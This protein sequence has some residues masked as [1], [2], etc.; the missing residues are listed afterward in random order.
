MT[1]QDRGDGG[2]RSKLRSQGLP[3][4]I[5]LDGDGAE[6]RLEPGARTG[7]IRAVSSAISRRVE[8]GSVVGLM[9]P[10]SPELVINWLASVH[11]GMK[12]V[13]MQYPTKKQNRA[14]WADSVRN[15]VGLA[16]IAA[17]IC[18]DLSASLLRG[19]VTIIAQEELAAIPDGPPE[20]FELDDF[21]IV[22]LSSGTTGHRKAIEFSWRQLQR[23]V[24]D[25]NGVLRLTA[26]DRVVS[27]LPLYHD[28]GYIAC[29]VMPMILGVEVVMVDPMAW[30]RRPS[31]LFD[32]VETYSGTICYMPN[33]GFEVMARVGKRA[34]PSMRWWIASAEPVSVETARRFLAAIG[35]AEETF[36]PSYAMAE[37]VFAI[38]I[39]RGLRTHVIGSAEVVS[40]GPP[41]P[42][43][44]VKIL[45][46]ELWVKS[47]ASLRAYVGGEDIRDEDGFYPT[48]DLGLIMDGEVYVTGRKQDVLVQAG[49]KYFLSDIDIALN[50]IYPWV[51]GRGAAVALDDAR[52][53]TQRPLVLIEAKDFFHRADQ[54]DIARSLESAVGL[55]Q[56]EVQFV[57]PRFLTKTSSGKFNR[58]KSAGDWALVVEARTSRSTARADP[59]GELRESFEHSNWDLPVEEILDSLSIEMLRIVL[60]GARAAYDGR[61]TLNEIAARLAAA[62]AAVVRPAAR[63]I[64]IVSLADRRIFKRLKEVH[65]DRLADLLGAPVV[66]EHLCLP[67][68][69]VLLSDLIFHDYFQP[70]LDQG[71]FTAVNRG[72]ETLKAASLIV[73]DDIAE[74]FFPPS[75][76]YGALSH[77]LQRDPVTDRVLVRWAPYA[78]RHDELPLTLVAGLDLPVSERTATLDL[79]STYL[80]TP[81]FKI[82]T[83]AGFDEETRDWDYRPLGGSGGTR[84][85]K[86]VL[87]AGDFVDELARWARDRPLERRGA[88]DSA[89]LELSDLSHFCS[90]LGRKKAIDLVLAK[91]DRF[92]IVGQRSSAPYIRKELE[93]QGKGYF[94][95]NSYAPEIIGSAPE[96]PDCV[97][98][99]GAQGEHKLDLPTVA[100]MKASGAWNTQ[101]IDDPI[102]DATEFVYGK[103][104]AP[105]SGYDWYYPF[106]LDAENRKQTAADAGKVRRQSMRDERRT[107]RG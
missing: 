12:P 48:G 103:A 68:S 8:R 60:T 80:G 56:V 85:S 62:P 81:V 21:A 49:R 9:Y 57:P 4:F 44:Q 17:I 96:R 58:Q 38:S 23:H 19:T 33:F 77:S 41:A 30:V 26:A 29:F 71:P 66:F 37:N 67:P 51:K 34:L 82:A 78:A 61:R 46:D 18:D 99:C 64:R 59:L 105:A 54:A 70:R 98:I 13:V 45:D 7:R 43:V 101:N 52:L 31:L 47:P 5:F 92:C 39:R 83:I 3:N 93:R 89:K 55:D 73:V 106:T 28:M 11:A 50:E 63:T 97:L 91:Y 102:L 88:G 86:M 94:Y 65:I 84:L 1:D 42:G 6:T 100:I 40:C 69:P 24:E 104:S 75:Q 32:A 87:N 107:R 20:P 74:M 10:S 27:W 79:L 16:A 90:Y 36:A 25:Y 35:G 53:G 22:Q 2:R 95:L 72:L 15:I 76:V 14:Y